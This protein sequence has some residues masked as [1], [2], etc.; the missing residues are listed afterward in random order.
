MISKILKTT[1]TNAGCAD[2]LNGRDSACRLL[3]FCNN[4]TF[5]LNPFHKFHINMEMGMAKITDNLLEPL[6][7][8]GSDRPISQLGT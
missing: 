2:T 8:T 7:N 4:T 1:C 3:A 6:G 5:P